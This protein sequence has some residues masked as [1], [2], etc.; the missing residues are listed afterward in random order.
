MVVP[1]DDDVLEMV[2]GADDDE[3]CLVS[4]CCFSLRRRLSSLPRVPSIT[5]YTS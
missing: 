4:N 1:G 3:G 5:A 2:F